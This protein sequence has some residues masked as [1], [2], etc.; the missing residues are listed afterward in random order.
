[1]D[2]F[3]TGKETDHA[4]LDYKLGLAFA[5]ASSSN[6]PAGD[7]FEPTF[8]RLGAIVQQAMME[9]GERENPD[10]T[11]NLDAFTTKVLFAYSER[12]RAYGKEY[13]Q[14]VSSAYPNVQLERIDG[15]G[16]SMITSETG[17][18]NF[19][20]IALTYLNEIK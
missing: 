7:A 20:P 15:T 8:W 11:T 2:Q 6:N 19:F 9:N 18:N 14:H 10:L 16:H 13:A 3:L 12:N 17:W 4:L 1:M 5:A